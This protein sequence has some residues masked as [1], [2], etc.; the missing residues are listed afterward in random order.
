MH[1]TVPFFDLVNH[2]VKPLSQESDLILAGDRRPGSQIA[3]T[4]SLRRIDQLNNR[5]GKQMSEGQGGQ[6]GDDQDDETAES[7]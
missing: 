1:V 5:P 7:Y 3:G 2:V 4:D 6:D